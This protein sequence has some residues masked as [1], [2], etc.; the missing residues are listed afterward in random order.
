MIRIQNRFSQWI[1][2]HQYSAMCIWPFLFI[3][4]DSEILQRPET[5][6][7]ERIH[8]RQQ[9]EMLW[10]FFFLWYG[11]EFVLRWFKLHNRH[12]AYLA[13]SHEKEAFKNDKDPGYLSKRKVLAWVKYL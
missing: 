2:G 7:H 6:N 1:L 8:A 12:K 10:L 3:K 9:L 13:L 4:A 5:L 11:I